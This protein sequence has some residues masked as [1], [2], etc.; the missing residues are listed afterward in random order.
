MKIRFKFTC[1]H[2]VYNRKGLTQCVNLSKHTYLTKITRQLPL[3]NRKFT[4]TLLCI[5]AIYIL[6]NPSPMFIVFLVE[7][8]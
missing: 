2:L 4:D 3:N 6:G 1:D 7:P 8:F 5:F